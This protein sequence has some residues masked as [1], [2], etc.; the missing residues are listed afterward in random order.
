MSAATI[1]FTDTLSCTASHGRL[2][3]STSIYDT[4]LGRNQ[5]KINRDLNDSLASHIN[6]DVHEHLGT[7]ERSG[8]A[9]D[10]A[11]S[12]DHS[13]SEHFVIMDYKVK[14]DSDTVARTGLILQ[15]VGSQRT[16]QLIIWDNTLYYRYITFTSTL[17][18]EIDAS[19]TTSWAPCFV[20][21]ISYTPSTRLLKLWWNNIGVAE[22]TLPLATG[23]TDG[24]LSAAD[25]TSILARLQ[26]I[27][28]KLNISK[29]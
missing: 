5:A 19:Q 3:L 18:D 7:F 6:A 10:I 20:N 4:Y 29:D 22:L 25:R 24:L 9:E 8:L 14:T 15:N 17:R 26:A 2:A 13:G 11:K 28:D 27:E 12:P 1:N 21:S 23:D 16:L